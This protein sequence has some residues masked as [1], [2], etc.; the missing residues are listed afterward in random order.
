[1]VTQKNCLVLSTQNIFIMLKLM[2]LKI[3]II[4]VYLNVCILIYN[5]DGFSHFYKKTFFEVLIS[6]NKIKVL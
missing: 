3:F 1:M 4:L 6:T 2:G 5:G